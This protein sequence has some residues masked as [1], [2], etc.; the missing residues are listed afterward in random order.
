MATHT[1]RKRASFYLFD[2]IICNSYTTMG[3]IRSAHRR[4]NIVSGPIPASAVKFYLSGF[5][6]GHH[7]AK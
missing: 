2:C 7:Y 3:Y 4:Q 5:E 1:K 6:T